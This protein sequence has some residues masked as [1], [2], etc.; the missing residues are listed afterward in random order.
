MPGF[1]LC[2][3]CLHRG[4]LVE[5]GYDPVMDIVYCSACHSECT[6]EWFFDICQF[7]SNRH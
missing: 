6:A 3:Y 4:R 1:V 2:Y 5:L 7:E